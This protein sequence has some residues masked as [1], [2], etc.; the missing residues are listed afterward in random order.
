MPGQAADCIRDSC[1]NLLE[2][3]LYEQMYY[4]ILGWSCCSSHQG[5][6]STGMPLCA[7][8]MRVAQQKGLK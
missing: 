8:A 7:T 1:M 5:M 4:I 3:H 6:V 2:W